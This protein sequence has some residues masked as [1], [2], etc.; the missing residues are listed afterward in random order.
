MKKDTNGEIFIF[1]G[2]VSGSLFKYRE[3][4]LE[5]VVNVKM[6]R[7]I[8]TPPSNTSGKLSF[9]LPKT[10]KNCQSNPSFW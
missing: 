5:E 9:G 6:L 7:H 4:I 2:L 1:L 10:L 3:N 8:L